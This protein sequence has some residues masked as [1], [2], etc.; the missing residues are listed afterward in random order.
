M[1]KTNPKK[2]RGRRRKE[3]KVEVIEISQKPFT[4]RLAHPK[5]PELPETPKPVISPEP[6]PRYNLERIM[7]YKPGKPI[8][9]V[10]RELKLTGRIIK[11]ASNE[12]PLGPSPR[13]LYAIKKFAHEVNLYPDDNGFYL[14]EKIAQKHDVPIDHI[15]IGNGSVELIYFACLAFLNPYDRLMRSAGSFL[16]PKIGADIIGATCQEIELRDYYDDMGREVRCHDLNKMLA[17]ITPQTKIIYLDN[18]I[19]PLGSCVWAKELDEFIEQVP[20]YVLVIIDEAYYDYITEKDYPDSLK[21]LQ[22]GKNVLILRTFSKI[23]GLAGLR[24]GYGISKPEIISAMSKVRTPFNVSRL[25]QIAAIA[26]LDDKNHIK[27]SRRL[28]EAGKKYL[29]RELK[30]LNIFYF[31]TYAN[32]IFVNFPIDSKEIFEQL[33]QRKIITRT[34][35]EY[36]FPNALRISI[37]TMAENR[38]LIKALQ[39][40]LS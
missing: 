12:N 14:K 37:G 25:A 4:P 40:I 39:E 32:F 11:L 30:K 34:I 27:R 26:A 7:P 36:G 9:A 2:R 5:K 33:Q 16:M 22:A 38:M 15:I 13:A 23:Y 6:L 18:P 10:A 20:N 1:D 17:A 35:K 19:N 31:P 8:E 29:Y 3:E 21:Y 28:N 24:I